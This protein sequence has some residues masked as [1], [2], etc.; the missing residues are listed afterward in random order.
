M[1][2]GKPRGLNSARKLRTHRRENRWSD[3]S[4]KKRLLGTAFKSSP[5]GGSSHAKGIV[6]EKIGV[7]AKQPNSAIRKCVRVQ[8][9]KNGKKVTAFVPNDGCLNFVDENDEVLLAGFGRKG[10]AKG[11]IPGVRFKVVKVSGVSLFALWKQKV[12]KPR[13]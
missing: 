6:L 8:L 4:Y 5:F 2:K 1:G 13:S 10:K 11:D 9:I 3:L 12:E 7:E